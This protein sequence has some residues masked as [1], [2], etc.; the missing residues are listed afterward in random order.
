MIEI[1]LNGFGRIGKCVFI[2]LLK[3]NTI[4]IKAINAINFTAY[5]LE[6]YIAYD[7]VHK[8]TEKYE[9]EIFSDSYFRIN[10]HKIKILSN[11]DAKQ[12]PWKQYGCTHIIDATGSYLTTD[13][14]KDH[15]VDYVIM[16][17]PPKDNTPTF[18]YGAN[19]DRYTGEN[20][21]SG[22][23]CT[24]NCLAPILT[25]LDDEYG[26]ISCNF[27]TI[28]ATTASQSTVDILSK[29][30]R[31]H[32]SILNNII[33]HTTGASS[34]I[35][36]IL[37]SLKGKIHGTSVRVPVSNCSL[38]DLNIELTNT[39]VT[40]DN[41]ERLIE[42]HEL[43]DIV[44]KLNKKNLVSCDFLTTTTPSILDVKSSI[45]MGNGKIKLMI[46]YD[47]E[48][49]YS[50]QLIRMVEYMNMYNEN[51]ISNST[52]KC[53]DP[54][55]IDNINMN[56][57]EV[58]ARFD[59]NVPL[60][61]GTITDEF[62]VQSAIPT[63]L[64]MINKGPRYIVLTSHFGRPV[65]KDS[66]FSLKVIVPVLE[67]YLDREVV[68]LENGISQDSLDI[69]KSTTKPT[70]YLL[71]NLRFHTEETMY[72]KMN[73]KQ[74]EESDIIQMYRDLGDIF[75]SD[76]FG[77]V[78]RKHM[79]ICDVKVSNKT[80]GYGYLI[81][82]EIDNINVLFQGNKKI[83]GIVGGNKIKDKMP[84]IDTLKTI[85]NTNIFVAGGI[86][87]VYK[88]N[89]KNVEVMSDGYGNKSLDDLNIKYF[90]E[91]TP[92][93]NMYD[94]GMKSMRKL[95][96]MIDECDIVLWNG[97]MGVIEDDR[98][99]VGSQELVEYLNYQTEKNVII[100]GGETAS[101]FNNNSITSH[102]YV[103][104]GG[105]ALLEY[106]QLKAIGKHLPGL[107]IFVEEKQ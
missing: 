38:L 20:I 10:H 106:I 53:K 6:D 16:S 4:S 100:G 7:S 84:L 96:K 52:I 78:H 80:Y 62:R 35:V 43:Y 37:P 76:A 71:E 85:P 67:K 99:I 40:I 91:M 25:M 27:T 77:C 36:N 83:L 64:S 1:G 104:T 14:C 75:I 39:S 41:I 19:E 72:A 89:D 103:S 68:F 31:T 61:R 17:A 79:S 107:E 30:S 15:D 105:G 59:F 97:S 57:K 94:I 9:L 50:A 2:Q 18:I 24:T 60:K 58:V 48:W 101:L 33:P 42:K 56:G 86:A 3:S 13:K 12:L 22:S 90:Q 69:L 73:K 46:W 66:L 11:R 5:D 95:Q 51:K 74:I 26:I 45:D 28:H 82:N 32:R 23:S 93:Y 47:N 8:Y 44:Y 34:S 87:S 102:I 88:S 29:N 65:Q 81:K 70:I 49:S 21:I 55:Y 54:F 92:D 63:I 98:Y